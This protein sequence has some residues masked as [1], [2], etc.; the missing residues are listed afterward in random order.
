MFIFGCDDR[1]EAARARDSWSEGDARS[2]GVDT[3]AR[4]TTKEG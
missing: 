4:V 1:D 2:P 3:G